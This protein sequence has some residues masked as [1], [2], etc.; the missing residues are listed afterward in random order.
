MS[1]LN[2]SAIDSFDRN[3][4]KHAHA[5]FNESN[6]KFCQS[7]VLSSKTPHKIYKVTITFIQISEEDAKIKRS[8]VENIMKKNYK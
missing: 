2:K 3:E 4:T 5:E 7:K 8:I 1:H 6:A